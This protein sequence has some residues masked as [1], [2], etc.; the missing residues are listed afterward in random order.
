MRFDAVDVAN[1]KP[2]LRADA[3]APPP[4]PTTTTTLAEASRKRAKQQDRRANNATVCSDAG[5]ERG[6]H[7]RARDRRARAAQPLA[8]LRRLRPHA[9]R[10]DRAPLRRPPGDGRVLRRVRARRQR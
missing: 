10:A 5:D 1:G 6:R 2:L 9:G 3:D 4:P 8:A 7:G